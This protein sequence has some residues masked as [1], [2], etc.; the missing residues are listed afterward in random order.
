MADG[1][2]EFVTRTE[3][4]EHRRSRFAKRRLRL[5]T[6]IDPTTAKALQD[7]IDAIVDHRSWDGLV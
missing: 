1:Y 4:S 3:M 2:A 5:R 7:E 6:Q